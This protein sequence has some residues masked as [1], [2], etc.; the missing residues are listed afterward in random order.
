MATIYVKDLDTCKLTLTP[1]APT[2][3]GGMRISKILYDNKQPLAVTLADDLCL[4]CPFHPSAYKAVGTEERLGIVIRATDE[5]HESFAA[6]E[7]HC[8]NLLEADGVEKV[9]GLWCASAREDDF[10]KTLRAK[11]K[12]CWFSAS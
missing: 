1:S 4:T 12:Y 8:R 2:A 6:L 10:G 3:K 7:D 11:N 5:I 9:D